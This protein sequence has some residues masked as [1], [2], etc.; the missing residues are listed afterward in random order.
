M[1]A[2]QIDRGTE[3]INCELQNWCHEN[4]MTIEK[5]APYSPTQ[6]G[7][8]ERMNRTLVELARSRN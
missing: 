4:G 6:N 1:H 3:F 8:V 2:I 5:T 7:V